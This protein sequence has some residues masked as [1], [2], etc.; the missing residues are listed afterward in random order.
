MAD[1]SNTVTLFWLIETVSKTFLR[2]NVVII[3]L[4]CNQLSFIQFGI[5]INFFNIPINGNL[6]I[7]GKKWFLHIEIQKTEEIIKKNKKNHV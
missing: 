3:I 7:H 1:I 5:W 4:S 2:K 6:S